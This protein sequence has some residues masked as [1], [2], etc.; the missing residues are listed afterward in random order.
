MV[1]PACYVA[2]P[3]L[4]GYYAGSATLGPRDVLLLT[5]LYLGFLGRILLKDFRDVRGDALFGKRTF[6]VRHGRRATCRFSAAMWMA[7]TVVLAAT[8]RWQDGS[9]VSYSALALGVL[10]L[11]AALASEHGPR[12]DE[13]LIATAAILGRGQLL[14]VLAQN[15]LA[16]AHWN[17]PATTAML[18]ALASVTA[19]QAWSMYR[20]GPPMRR[21]A[22]PIP[23]A[24]HAGP[25]GPDQ[26][27]QAG[28]EGPRRKVG[29][30][31]AGRSSHQPGEHLVIG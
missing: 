9:A 28:S 5:G 11:I 22:V 12:R 27:D 15:Q 29:Q 21:F 18:L 14:T 30:P 7:G 4:I 13:V 3:F 31:G 20:N 1:L 26:Y 6:L 24:A 8:G 16:A 10:V 19:G 17:T 2:T 23:A 25:N